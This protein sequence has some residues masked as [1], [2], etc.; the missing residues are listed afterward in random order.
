MTTPGIAALVPQ[1]G[2]MCLLDEI[3]SFD[4]GG[5]VCRTASHRSIANPLRCDGRLPACAGIEYGAQA[6]AA[7]GA[8]R[9]SPVPQVQA[10]LLA[11][12]RALRLNARFLDDEPGPLTVRA[13]RLVAEGDRLL[14]AFAVESAGRELVGGRIAVVLRPGGAR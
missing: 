3:V 1:Q 13:E 10:G 14:Y 5:I 6:M 4:E 8:L 7:H 2:A 12:A 9:A 11:G